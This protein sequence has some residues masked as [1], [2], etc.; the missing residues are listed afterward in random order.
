MLDSSFS[1]V[2]PA[3]NEQAALGELIKNIK[4]RHPLS[5]IIV[6]ND[7]SADD[8]AEEAT[9]AGAR[10]ITHRY[11]IGNGGAIK[12]GARAATRNIVVFMD[13]DGQHD[14]ADIIRLLNE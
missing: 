13:G 9:R 10:V 1:I 6:V 12:S 11:S 3:K 4:L 2:I 5:E 8:T 14:P 7:G